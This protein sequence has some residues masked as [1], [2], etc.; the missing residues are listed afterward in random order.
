M[1]EKMDDRQL[2]VTRTEERC[3]TTQEWG[4]SQVG[5]HRQRFE[6]VRTDGKK[7]INVGDKSKFVISH[8]GKKCVFDL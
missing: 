2:M 4:Q 7:K 5:H 3:R 1:D 8:V 6:Q